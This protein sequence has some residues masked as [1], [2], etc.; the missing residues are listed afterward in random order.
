MIRAVP[1]SAIILSS[2]GVVVRHRSTA[3]T[4]DILGAVNVTPKSI[5]P[6]RGIRWDRAV[7]SRICLFDPRTAVCVV[8][9]DRAKPL[10]TDLIPAL[11]ARIC[12]ELEL[13]PKT[14]LPDSDTLSIDAQISKRLRIINLD[15]HA[16][17]DRVE[18]NGA[19]VADETAD[20]T[21]NLHFP[22]ARTVRAAKLIVANSL[23]F[24]VWNRAKLVE[25]VLESR[26]VGRRDDSLLLALHLH[27]RCLSKW[28]LL[29]QIILL[30]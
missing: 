19:P 1:A 17:D 6:D 4:N 22:S 29:R 9:F 18:E 11:R 12:T 10:V 25:I 8:A 15:G 26:W 27:T 13:S 24:P 30:G 5:L 3:A 21:P 23:T 16:E 2:R 20:T 7:P 14:R 28:L